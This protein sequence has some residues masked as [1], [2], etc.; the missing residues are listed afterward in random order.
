MQACIPSFRDIVFFIL[1]D[2][3]CNVGI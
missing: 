1:E 3:L 2:P